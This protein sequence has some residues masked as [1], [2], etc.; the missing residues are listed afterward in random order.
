MAKK[1]GYI[2]VAPPMAGKWYADKS[3]TFE[4]EFLVKQLEEHAKD[5][6]NFKVIWINKDE[7]TYEAFY[8]WEE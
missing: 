1:Y 7:T 4:G 8:E 3:I 6:N 5:K 2:P